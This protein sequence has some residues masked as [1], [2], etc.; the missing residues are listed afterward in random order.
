MYTDDYA[1]QKDLFNHHVY[2]AWQFI[3]YTR[4]NI[5]V[6]EYCFTTIKNIIE[7]MTT[8]TVRWEQDLFS[9]FVE[10]IIVD[11][12]K[13]KRISVTTENQPVY[14]LRVAGEKVD[15]WFLFDKLLRDFY[16][17]S[18]NS[19]DSI[20]QIANAGL[21][22]NNAKKVDSVDFQKMAST[23]AQLTYKTAFPKTSAWFENVNSSSEF[24]YIEAINNRTKHTADI[25]N[26]L[27][28]GILGSSNKAEIGPFFRKELQHSKKN[29]TD[30]LQATLDFLNQVWNDFLVSFCDEFILDTYVDNR[31]HKIGGVYQ[32]RLKDEPDQDLSYAFIPV[33]N[34]FSN[35]PDNIHILLA[36]DRDGIGAHICPF[37]NILVREGEHNIVGRYIA[38]DSVGED[39]S[40]TYRKYT[41][42]KITA[43]AVCMFY[44]QQNG[45]TFYH[46]NPF[47]TVT[48]VSNDDNLIARSSLPF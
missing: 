22:A 15:P 44:E 37:Q 39:C 19:L 3:T 40:L 17:Y 18:M 30:Q 24:K 8:K 36:Y 9:D 34:D 13:A 25:S 38:D 2:S 45:T 27:S 12:K 4:K 21:L 42:D 10:D 23:F 33:E 29:L 26:K 46:H 11:G 1:F 32:Q 31:R 14:E 47:F 43:G 6:V 20:S 28:M 7:K 35:M 48:T 16:Q 5:D 41:K